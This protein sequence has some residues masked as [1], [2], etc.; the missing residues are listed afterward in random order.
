[1]VTVVGAE[2]VNV[3]A[4]TTTVRVVDPVKLPELPVI[5]IVLLPTFALAAAV[6]VNTLL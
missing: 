1:M 3:G 6:S 4:N 2:M 5:V